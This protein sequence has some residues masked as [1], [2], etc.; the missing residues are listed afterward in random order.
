MGLKS[1]SLVI[2]VPSVLFN[3][4]FLCH[5][6]AEC[7]ADMTPDA[8]SHFVSHALYLWLFSCDCGGG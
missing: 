6:M 3:L 1:L 5:V 4:V 7:S 2:G 8:G